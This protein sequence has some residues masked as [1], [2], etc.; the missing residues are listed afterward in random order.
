VVSS[1]NVDEKNY[2]STL[3][4]LSF[5]LGAFVAAIQKLKV[6]VPTLTRHLTEYLIFSLQ[7]HNCLPL[8]FLN[9]GDVHLI[10][11]LFRTKSDRID[12]VR[13]SSFSIVSRCLFLCWRNEFES[14][15]SASASRSCYIRYTAGDCIA[16]RIINIRGPDNPWLTFT[17]LAVIQRWIMKDGELDAL[18]ESSIAAAC[19]LDPVQ[20]IYPLPDCE[21]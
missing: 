16:D 11:H 13:I 4:I 7:L 12:Y 10:S 1:V 5:A 14:A 3:Y 8:N 6:Y 21:Q 2:T 18:A 19:S 15:I 20:L 17:C 9:G